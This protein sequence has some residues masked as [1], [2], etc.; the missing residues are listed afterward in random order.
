MDILLE[1]LYDLPP[2]EGGKRISP[3]ESLL[4]TEY[5]MALEG[6]GAS[7][8]T[9]L[10]IMRHNE[11]ARAVR[12]GR[13]PRAVFAPEPEPLCDYHAILR[14]LGIAVRLIPPDF[15]TT[16]EYGRKVRDERAYERYPTLKLLPWAF[17][18]ALERRR[19][20]D[21]KRIHSLARSVRA[22]GTEDHRPVAITPEWPAKDPKETRFK[23]GQS[24]NPKGRP[25][26]K[27]LEPLPF[28]TFLDEQI[29]M[30]IN[31]EVRTM[32]RLEGLLYAQ[33]A[34][35]MKGYRGVSRMLI[36]ES[37]AEL[38]ARWKRK[39]GP[40][41]VAYLFF[42]SDPDP[43][44]YFLDGLEELRIIH[45]RRQGHVMLERWIVEAAVQ[46]LQEPLK[47]A[48]QVAVL[49]GTPC[50]RRVNWP[51]WWLPHL[52][53]KAPRRR[54]KKDDNWGWGNSR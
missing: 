15:W 36:D 50:P 31:N 51:D 53:E 41:E 47:E 38:Y 33:Q 7:L 10:K 35:A 20:T 18:A 21:D 30:R 48:E 6:N 26:K 28:E 27:R 40:V 8:K 45:R 17:D 39:E 22:A 37:I 43:D 29:T 34:R 44:E 42:G 5:R 11:R 52:R 24:G 13:G 14:K 16:D 49:R 19:I 9:I 4:R 12:D 32:S 3:F 54:V 46:R 23:K 2:Q 25:R 1:P